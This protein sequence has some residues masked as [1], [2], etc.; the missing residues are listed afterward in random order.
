M[1]ILD[2]I[3]SKLKTIDDNLFFGVVNPTEEMTYWD[4]IVFRRG[5]LRKSENGTGYTRTYI[6]G[7]VR[8]NYIPDGL[9]AAVISA[10]LE[11]P[12]MRVSAGD[13]AYDYVERPGTNAAVEILTLNFY[14]PEKICDGNNA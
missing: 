4:Y 9:D 3:E 13:N 5:T 14:R 2:D 1:S 7:I 11:I 8:E 6:V 12:G 10:M